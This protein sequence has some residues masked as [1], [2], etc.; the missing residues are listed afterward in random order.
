MMGKPSMKTVENDSGGA[1]KKAELCASRF[2]TERRRA[3]EPILGFRRRIPSSTNVTENT[4]NE[5][6]TM[7]S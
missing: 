2:K 3:S 7:K 4:A 1:A 5:R 6:V